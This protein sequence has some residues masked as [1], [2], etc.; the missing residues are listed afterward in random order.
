MDE[1]NE[2]KKNCERIRRWLSYWDDPGISEF[3]EACENDGLRKGLFYGA[4]VGIHAGVLIGVI[5][6]CIAL[7]TI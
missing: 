7:K 6:A 1:I 3:G 4:L 5:V 2:L